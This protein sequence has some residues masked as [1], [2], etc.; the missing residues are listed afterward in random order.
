MSANLVMVSVPFA[1]GYEL[2][3]VALTL[4]VATIKVK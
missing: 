1:A 4:V 2:H 3:Q